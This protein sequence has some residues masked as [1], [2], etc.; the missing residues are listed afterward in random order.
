MT[1][2]P[3]VDNANPASIRQVDTSRIA[4]HVNA[5]QAGGGS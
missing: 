1:S 4:Q 5:A 2:V 3:L